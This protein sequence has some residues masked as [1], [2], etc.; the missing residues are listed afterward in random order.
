V[1]R[2]DSGRCD[3]P[4]RCRRWTIRRRARPLARGQRV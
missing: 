2:L 1:A 4:L 3:R